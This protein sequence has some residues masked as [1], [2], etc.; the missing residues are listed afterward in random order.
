LDTDPNYPDPNYPR[1]VS[2]QSS[3]NQTV[4]LVTDGD[5]RL[6]F[7]DWL[8]PQRIALV[9]AWCRRLKFA[10]LLMRINASKVSQSYSASVEL[11]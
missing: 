8:D 11:T 6:G 7:M 5:S 9:L 2:I 1:F 10:F 3:G 4:R